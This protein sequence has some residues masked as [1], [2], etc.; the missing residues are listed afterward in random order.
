MS[1]SS[2]PRFLVKKL[3]ENATI[4]VRASQSAAGYDL[5]RFVEP[6][7]T[8]TYTA[9]SAVDTA[10]PP[11]GKAVVQTD[12]AI[13]VPE[14]FYGRVGMPCFCSCAYDSAPRSGLAVKFHIDV[15]GTLVSVLCAFVVNTL[16]GCDGYVL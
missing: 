1:V 12:I 15:G 13:A 2:A 16:M 7:W 3:S 11:Q 10:V 9:S 14:G 5:C 6:K 8:H 4:P